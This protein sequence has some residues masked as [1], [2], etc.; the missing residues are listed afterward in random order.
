VIRLRAVPDHSGSAI[1]R[2]FA[3]LRLPSVPLPH[4]LWIAHQAGVVCR[5]AKSSGQGVG[6]LRAGH[7]TPGPLPRIGD[8]QHGRLC[9]RRARLDEGFNSTPSSDELLQMPL[10]VGR[11][12]SKLPR[13]SLAEQRHPASLVHPHL[14]ETYLIIQQCPG[15]RSSG[16]TVCH[17]THLDRV[18]GPRRLPRSLGGRGLSRSGRM[19]VGNRK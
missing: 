9:H 16:D 11:R 14:S 3:L 10:V 12:R 7:S 19:A 18:W 17:N 1:V 8:E 6:C 5:N 15:P 13:P 4:S 2:A